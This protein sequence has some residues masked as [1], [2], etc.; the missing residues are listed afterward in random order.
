MSRIKKIV[1]FTIATLFIAHNLDLDDKFLYKI[2]NVKANEITIEK[3]PH[4]DELKVIK[5]IKKNLSGIT[6]SPKTD[7]LFAITNSPRNIYELNKKG[8]IL[9]T[10][11]LKGFEDTE[12]ITYIKDNKFAILDER[13]DSLYVEVID[14]N[15]KTISTKDALKKFTYKIKNFKNFGYEG[16][17][18]ND[19]DDEFYI[20]NERN[21]K[22]VISVKG[23]MTNSQIKV[24]YKD[25]ITNNNF[26]L[27]DF[28]AIYFDNKNNELL[29]LSEES[30]LLAEVNQKGEFKNFLDLKENEITSQVLH[31]EG[32][33]MDNDGNIYIV[34][35][36]NLF[37]S[38]K[39]II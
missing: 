29:I 15:T 3:L 34:S 4:K 2:F 35:E 16:V 25:E 22:K 38:I 14:K 1:V 28:S 31:A 26:Y 20:V 6:Y 24:S 27:G 36:P 19:L 21:P 5:Q 10:I 32:I 23:L 39:K 8:D 18:Y 12:D 37:L 13:T 33:T 17:S 11:V 9:R 30:S 7:T